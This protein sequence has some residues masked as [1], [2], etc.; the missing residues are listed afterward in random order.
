MDATGWDVMM[1]TTHGDTTL[2][3]P[4]NRPCK[5]RTCQEALE[6]LV[7][8]SRHNVSHTVASVFSIG[9]VETLM[10]EPSATLDLNFNSDV[11]LDAFSIC[12]SV[13][14]FLEDGQLVF[15]SRT[16]G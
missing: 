8:F 4:R 1:M 13:E 14:L 6:L 11:I 16:L 10:V 3:A 2:S 5:V 12:T 9:S 15:I 7:G